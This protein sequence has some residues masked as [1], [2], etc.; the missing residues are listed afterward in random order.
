MNL[1]YKQKRR[2]L[3]SAVF[4]VALLSIFILGGIKLE[5]KS[6][7]VRNYFFN[8][9]DGFSIANDIYVRS[10]C[11][12]NLLTIAKRIDVDKNAV[13]TLEK[14]LA[15]L[16]TA[17]TVNEYFA[18]NEALTAAFDTLYARIDASDA[19]ESDK[20]LAAKQ[21]D[22]FASRAKTIQK[23]P[24]NELAIDFNEEI[25]KFPANIISLLSGTDCA[26]LFRNGG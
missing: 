1:K 19:T 22:E 3:W 6:N 20:R 9:E 10:E 15:E 21:A 25:S 23:D 14:T 13:K 18:A 12:F 7:A 2:I 8:G 4:A 26:Q 11:G 16:D 24:Y 5:A 17:I